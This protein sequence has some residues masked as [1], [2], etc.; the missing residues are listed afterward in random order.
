[1][2]KKNKP[3]NRSVIRVIEVRVAAR[4]I[5]VLGSGECVREGE[6]LRSL[7][8]ILLLKMRLLLLSV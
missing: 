6:G 7:R 1:M 5:D 8:C 3:T 4:V 2:G